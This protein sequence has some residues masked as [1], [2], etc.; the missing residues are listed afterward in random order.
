MEKYEKLFK[1]LEMCA[2]PECS[3]DCPYHGETRGGKTC[4]AWLLND[5]AAAI[6]NEEAG[7][8][9]LMELL[10]NTEAERDE[11]AKECEELK[12]YALAVEKEGQEARAERDKLNENMTCIIRQRDDLAADKEALR[13]ANEDLWAENKIIHE[14]CQ[15]QQNEINALVL[16]L[17][18]GKEPKQEPGLEETMNVALKATMQAEYWRGQANAMKGFLRELFEDCAVEADDHV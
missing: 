13:V 10:H 15:V 2:G 16:K 9:T 5:A 18:E 3:T 11:L 6:L 12:D 17:G 14:R 7:G 1:G 4:R 8:D